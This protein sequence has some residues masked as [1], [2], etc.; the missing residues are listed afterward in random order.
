VL[1][2]ILAKAA[3]GHTARTLSRTLVIGGATLTVAGG[4]S[5]GI[6]VRLTRKGLALL[7]ARRRLRCRLTITATAPGLVKP[8]SG[9]W[10]LE[11]K[12]PHRR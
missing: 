12:R 10:T 4:R 3:G 1:T 7:R 8:A 5:G 2:A 9:S 6:D 11:L